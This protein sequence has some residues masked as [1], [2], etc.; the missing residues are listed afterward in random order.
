MSEGDPVKAIFKGSVVKTF[1]MPGY[2]QCVVLSHGDHMS[3]YCRLTEVSVKEGAKVTTG[4]VI[5]KVGAVL[6]DTYLHFEIWD[7]SNQA[8]DP[9]KWLK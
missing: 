7:S 9:E 6:G 2:G 4:Q 5:G 8:V 3:L 1:N